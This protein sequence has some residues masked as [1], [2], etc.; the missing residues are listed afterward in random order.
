MSLRGF[1]QRVTVLRKGSVRFNGTVPQLMAVTAANR[2]LVRLHGDGLR[3][4]EVAERAGAALATSGSI[5]P[6]PEGDGEHFVLALRE[7][8]SI[9]W[10]AARLL[11]AGVDMLACREERSAVETAFLFLTEDDA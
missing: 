5:A 1:A 2:F 3:G 7:E 6:G 10:A 9:G 4:E 11:D 8:V